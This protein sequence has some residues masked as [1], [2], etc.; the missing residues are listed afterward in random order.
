MNGIARSLGVWRGTAV[1]LN[2]VLGAGLLILPG[3]AIREGGQGALAAWL[4]AAAAALPLLA[5]FVVL[6]KRHA[7]AGGVAGLAK[8]AFGPL[9]HLVASMLFLGAVCVGLPAI[10]L[11][12]GHYAVSVAG[13][14]VHAWA[15]LLVMVVFAVNACSVKLAGTISQGLSWSI[16]IFVAG[17][18]AVCGW[19]VWDLPA[20]RLAWPWQGTEGMTTPLALFPMVF[21]AFT[22]W[23]VAASLAEDFHQSH[24]DFPRAMVASFVIAVSFYLLMAYIAQRADLDAGLEAPFATIVGAHLGPIGARLVGTMACVLLFA[25]LL[26]ATWAISRMVFSLARE[27]ILPAALGRLHGEQPRVAL[28]AFT[29]VVILVIALDYAGV[30][31]SRTAFALSGQNFFLIY[32]IVAAS[33]LKMATGTPERCLAVIAIAV[34]VSLSAAQAGSLAYPAAITVAALAMQWIRS[35]RVAPMVDR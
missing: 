30:L 15:A 14:S 6:G 1:M 11:T 23:E 3:L 26:G 19:L 17:L 33:L 13:G 21:F 27:R 18:A 24:R 8:R 25:N 4:I 10:A 12:A 7:D 16:G 2:I 29:C 28:T 35:R 9:G 22:G 32:G 34:V 20:P 5:V 31:D